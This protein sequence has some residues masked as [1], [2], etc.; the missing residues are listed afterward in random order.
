MN[1]TPKIESESYDFFDVIDTYIENGNVVN[2]NNIT[3]RE[4]VNCTPFSKVYNGGR[5]SQIVKHICEEFLKIYTSIPNLKNRKTSDVNYKKDYNFVNY[6]LNDKIRES[7]LNRSACV[8]DFYEEMEPQCSDTLSLIFESNYIYHIVEKDF[9]K[10]KLLFSLYTNYSKLNSILSKSTIENPESLLGPSTICSN[11]YKTAS[12]LCY[13]EKGKFCEKL[14]KFKLKYEE[15]YVTLETKEGELSKYFKRLP[16]DENNIIST[17]VIGSMAGL[18]PLF[19]LLYKFTPMGQLFKSK[20]AELT[21][22][23]RDNGGEME[24]ISLID[25]ENEHFRFHEGAYNIKYQ[26][27]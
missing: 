12:Y 3:S 7:E 24:K 25:Q 16:E 19:G 17:A 18:I 9:T 27:V 1:C 8:D 26:S 14:D 23:Y 11:D 13:S 5:N 22:A 15:L 2:K 10:M 20:K 6:W 21:D 4:L